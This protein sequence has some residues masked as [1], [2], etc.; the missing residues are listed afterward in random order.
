MATVIISF[1]HYELCLLPV[2]VVRKNFQSCE[3]TRPSS[4]DLDLHRLFTSRCSLFTPRLRPYPLLILT[5]IVRVI[6]LIY[7]IERV[8]LI[9]IIKKDP[10]YKSSIYDVLVENAY[11]ADEFLPPLLSS[12]HFSPMLI[13]FWV[14]RDLPYQLLL[15][16]DHLVFERLKNIY[17][18]NEKVRR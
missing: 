15:Q 13:A 7:I 1:Q 10:I 16:T 3:L 17:N 6:L 4:L 18:Q 2:T 12:Q 14:M 8:W 11:Q 5:F 9:L